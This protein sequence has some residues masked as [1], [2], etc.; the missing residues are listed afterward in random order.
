MS[1]MATDGLTRFVF[2]QAD[3]RG[4][5]VRLEDSLQQ[6]MSLHQY[7][8]EIQQ[9]LGEFLVAS[10]LLSDTIKFEGHLTLQVNGRGRVHLL[11]A[12]ATHEGHVRGIARLDDT[13]ADDAWSGLSLR[14]LLDNGTLTVTI[15]ARGRERYQSIVPLEGETLGDCLTSY[16]QQSEQLNTQIFLAAGET[17]A[18][19][20]LIQQL[21]VQVEQN[22]A[23]RNDRWETVQT[24]AATLTVGEMLQDANEVLIRHLFAEENIRV[25]PP[26]PVSFQCSCSEER[27]AGAL[28]SIGEQE[29][30]TMFREQSTLEMVCEFCGTQYLIDEEKLV[31]LATQGAHL[32]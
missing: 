15:D 11:M 18:A 26:S 13:T 14:E 25:F 16:F 29:L 5:I 8:P 3:I 19:G 17:G 6:L 4:T 10:L 27:M 20:M 12:E 31:Q 9:L 23:Q 2:T 22:L 32:H 24:L 28:V 1:D 30:T 7:P 21:P